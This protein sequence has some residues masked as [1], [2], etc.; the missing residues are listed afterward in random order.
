ML[1]K[2]TRRKR[3]ASVDPEFR[4]GFYGGDRLTTTDPKTLFG[5]T[6]YPTKRDRPTGVQP[7]G[8]NSSSHGQTER[9][10]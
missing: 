2:R 5:Q 8:R 6:R 1:E 9:Q 10:G 7:S 3:L 4:A